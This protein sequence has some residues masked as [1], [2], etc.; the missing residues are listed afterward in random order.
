MAL[1]YPEAGTRTDIGINSGLTMLDTGRT[2]EDKVLIV[3][4]DGYSDNL[5][6]TKNA[7]TTAKADGATVYAVGVGGDVLDSE[8]SDI[9]SGTGYVERATNFDTVLDSLDI[10]IPEVNLC[11]IVGCYNFKASSL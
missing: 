10:G 3:I 11:G 7:S 4:T 1:P 5:E 8:L 9:A 6:L 2:G